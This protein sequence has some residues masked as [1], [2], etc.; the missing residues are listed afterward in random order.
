M[1]GKA[2]TYAWKA[3]SPVANYWYGDSSTSSAT[4]GSMVAKGR[5]K[6]S[7]FVLKRTGSMYFDEDGHLAHEFYIEV[8]PSKNKKLKAGMKRIENNL[9]P[10][11]EIEHDIPRLHV[12]LPMIMCQI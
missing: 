6:V 5:Y 7:P 11:G 9:T 10:Q 8:P 2:S 12:D 3:V 4:P 1:G